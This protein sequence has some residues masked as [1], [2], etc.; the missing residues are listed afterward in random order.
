MSLVQFA[1]V[2]LVLAI[3]AYVYVKYVMPAIPAPIGKIVLAIFAGIVC[4]WL[5]DLVGVIDFGDMHIG[6]NRRP[7]LD[8][9]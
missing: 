7:I 1:I 4:L 6:R 2:L 9:D 8:I 5:L 3:A